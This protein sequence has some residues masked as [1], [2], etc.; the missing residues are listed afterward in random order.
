ERDQPLGELHPRWA[1]AVEAASCLRLAARGLVD[2]WV[3]VPEHDR[4]IRAHQVDVLV[5]V[6]VPDARARAAREEV[7]V[8]RGYQHA[9]RLVAVDATGHDAQRAFEEGVGLAVT[10]GRRHAGASRWRSRNASIAVF[11]RWFA[12]PRQFTW[13]ACGAPSSSSSSLALP[14]SSSAACMRSDSRQ[15]TSW[16][17]VPWLS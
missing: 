12:S 5:A 16:S 15:E 7:R 9:R 11:A 6:D 13:N 14:A 8:G 2:P 10:A 3:V 17:A 4:A 1:R